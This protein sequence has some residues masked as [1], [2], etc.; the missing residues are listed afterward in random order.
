MFALLIQPV[1]ALPDDTIQILAQ[2]NAQYFPPG[3]AIK[4]KVA[5]CPKGLQG[6][7]HCMD[8]RLVTLSA[9]EGTADRQFVPVGSRT[10]EE[11]AEYRY[12]L[13]SMNTAVLPVPNQ[14]GSVIM[15]GYGDRFTDQ[16]YTDDA[17]CLN[18]NVLSEC[19]GQRVPWKYR[20]LS[21]IKY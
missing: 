1:V 4:L 17:R 16:Y 20:G 9:V 8:P 14:N 3:F 13:H 10:Q 12:R 21:L 2:G 11:P 15:I 6:L 7:F 19:D 18:A 5:V